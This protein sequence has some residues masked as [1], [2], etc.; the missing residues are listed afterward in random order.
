MSLIKRL[1]QLSG[2]AIL[3][4]VCNH[5]IQS[6]LA[7]A[8]WAHGSTPPPDYTLGPL[9]YYPLIIIEKLAVFSVPAFLFVSGFFVAYSSRGGRQAV[10]TWKMAFSRISLLLI[11]YVVWSAIIFL[12][13]ASQH[14]LMSPERYLWK[15]LAG[16]AIPPFYFVPLLCQFYLLAPLFVQFNKRHARTTLG[17]AA[18]VQGV[19]IG[20][21]YF[22]EGRVGMGLWHLFPTWILFFAGGTVAGFNADILRLWLAKHRRSLLLAA[23][24]FGAVAVLEADLIYR[25]LGYSDWRDRPFT[26]PTSLYG[27]AFILAFLAYDTVSLPFPAFFNYLSSRTYGIYLIHSTLLSLLFIAAGPV[28]SLLSLYPLLTQP[29][30]IALALG[31]PLGL[32]WLVLQTPA[33]R[34]YRHLFG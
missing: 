13:D 1:S 11:P 12:I 3:A 7:L 15:L 2:L 28:L 32:M 24:L 4:V 16:T 9:I 17:L 8:G 25:G 34:L 26:L 29:V 33:R 22:V 18:I 19:M 5:S 20:T 31:V 27:A 21:S 10:F 14:G 23:V 6:G 30:L